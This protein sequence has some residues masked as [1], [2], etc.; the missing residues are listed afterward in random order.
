MSPAKVDPSCKSSSTSKS[1]YPRLC[2]ISLVSRRRF[3]DVDGCLLLAAFSSVSSSAALCNHLA[4]VQS[5]LCHLVEGV[6]HVQVSGRLNVTGHKFGEI[7]GVSRL[8]C[9]RNKGLPHLCELWLKT[10]NQKRWFA[11]RVDMSK[12]ERR[13]HISMHHCKNEVQNKSNCLLTSS[14]LTTEKQSRNIQCFHGNFHYAPGQSGVISRR[15]RPIHFIHGCVL[16]QARALP[17]VFIHDH[18]KRLRVGGK[19]QTL[20]NWFSRSCSKA[21]RA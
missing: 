4:P 19:P 8:S 14:L 9:L 3:L 13:K 15:F 5:V 20:T 18:H 10:Q 16:A 6:F 12:T 21:C 11:I 2:K 7:C 1:S 17:E